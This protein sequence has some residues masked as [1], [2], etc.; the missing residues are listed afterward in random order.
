MAKKY[1]PK[2][3]IAN[4]LTSVA[5]DHIVATTD[6]LY[7]EFLQEYQSEINKQIIGGDR[8]FLMY[9]DGSNYEGNKMLTKPVISTIWTVELPNGTEET[10][11]EANITVPTGST[12]SVSA[13]VANNPP[14]N[15]VIP[16]KMAGNFGEKEVDNKEEEVLPEGQLGTLLET[17]IASNTVFSATFLGLGGRLKTNSEG[18]VYYTKDDLIKTS[19]ISVIFKYIVYWGTNAEKYSEGMNLKDLEYSGYTSGTLKELDSD[20]NK[21][22]N[23]F[24]FNF[25][26]S[27]GKYIYFV[28]PKAFGDISFEMG[29]FTFSD[30]DEPIVT[31]IDGIEYNVYIS[32]T[33]YN[34]DNYPLK[35]IIK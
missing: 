33:L 25:D 26:C 32:K 24:D 3:K 4:A 21:K 8:S 10:S 7:D 18:Y 14:E 22:D 6:D 5:K 1:I 17:D 23:S 12:V 27:G 13:V 20:K 31:S 16:Y 29:G 15:E 28:S 35:F 11:T 34:S 30:F 2:G 19:L 9:K